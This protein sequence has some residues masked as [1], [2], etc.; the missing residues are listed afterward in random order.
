MKKNIVIH[1]PEQLTKDW[2]QLIIRQHDENAQVSAVKIHSVSVGTTTRIRLSVDHNASTNLPS[3]WFV[4]TPSLSLNSRLIT[5]L[6][7]L[8]QKEINFYNQLSTQAPLK[9]APILAAEKNGVFGTTLVMADVEEMGYRAGQSSDALSLLQAQKVIQHLAQ[10][11]GQFWQNTD[12]LQNYPWLNGFNLQAERYLGSLLAV[13]L[14]KRGLAKAGKLVPAALYEPALRYATNRAKV[15]QF[16]NQAPLTLTHFD[17]H[18]GNFFWT[19]NEPGFLDWQLVRV[20]EA[21]ADV[22]Y[23]L[24]T[25]LTPENRR[26]YQSDLLAD[27][28]AGLIDQ[29]IN[30]YNQDLLY[31]RYRAHL[32][33]AFEA[34]I[35]TLAIGNMMDLDS[36]LE[37]IRRTSAAVLDN[38]GFAALEI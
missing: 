3:R 16:L 30:H 31:Q 1:R 15:I 4:K 24:A 12:I 17:C 22:A 25:S 28:L 27:Y 18:P 21:V 37:L 34:M 38:A 19:D 6:P 36:N 11:H 29:G 20:A 13:P 23:F 26:S 8:L 2:A 14:M 32:C 10:F 33:Y 35:I 9:L 5:F 7:R